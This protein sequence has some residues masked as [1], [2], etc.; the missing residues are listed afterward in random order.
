MKTIGVAE[1]KKSLSK[2]LRLAQHEDVMVMRHGRPIV[3]LHRVEEGVGTYEGSD[4]F[5]QTI[6]DRLNGPTITSEELRRDLGFR[7]YRER[8]PRT[9]GTKGRQR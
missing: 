1:M 4:E 9:N 7:P 8:K 5:W 3:R 2:T 6:R